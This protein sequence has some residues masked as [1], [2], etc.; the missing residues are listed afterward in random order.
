MFVYQSCKA[1]K[2]CS[3]KKCSCSATADLDV[4]SLQ[5][6][7]SDVSRPPSQGPDIYSESDVSGP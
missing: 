7:E 2:V 3:R 1:V 5:L 6:D 4:V